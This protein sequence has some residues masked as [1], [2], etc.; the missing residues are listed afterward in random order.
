MPGSSRPVPIWFWSERLRV[1]RVR[2]TSEL[3]R[4]ADSNNASGSENPDIRGRLETLPTAQLSQLMIARHNALGPLDGTPPSPEP[5]TGARSARRPDERREACGTDKVV[6]RVKPV[7]L[8]NSC[9]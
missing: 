2:R 4:F 7:E 5:G 8:P 3:D 6:S 1:R 9:S